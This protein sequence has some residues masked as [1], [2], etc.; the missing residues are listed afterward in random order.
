[1]ATASFNKD[2]VVTDE[3]SIQQLKSELCKPRVVEVKKRDQKK[4]K[5]KGISLLRQ[6]LS[7]LDLLEEFG[8]EETSKLFLD[9]TC[10]KKPDVE[11]F[12]RFKSIRFEESDSVRTYLILN[13]EGL[14]LAYF[15]ISF[16]ELYLGGFELAKTQ[17]KKLD[18]MRKDVER[19][20]VFLIGQLAKNYSV[21]DNVLTL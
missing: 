5:V 20:R 19:L 15:S 7:S 18:G 12:I 13:E 8:K 3:K 2:F 21:D 4:D 11:D 10:P 6:R 9:F 16:K 17:V 14:I 1:M